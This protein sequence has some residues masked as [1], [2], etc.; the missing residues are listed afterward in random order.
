MKKIKSLSILLVCLIALAFVSCQDSI[1]V[2]DNGGGSGGGGGGSQISLIVTGIPGVPADGSFFFYRYV[3]ALLRDAESIARI[4]RSHEQ[5]IQP[6]VQIPATGEFTM[7]N[8]LLVSQPFGTPGLYFVDLFFNWAGVGR[9]YRTTLMNINA[10]V[11]TIPF[12]AFTVIPF[13]QW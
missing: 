13:G 9:M 10:G 2:A 3:T 12:S 7:F 1:T 6:T 5:D 8:Y 11:N 4:A